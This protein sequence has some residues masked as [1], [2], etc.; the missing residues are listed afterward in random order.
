MLGSALQTESYLTMASIEKIDKLLDVNE[1]KAKKSV[2]KKDIGYPSLVDD[3]KT[4]KSKKG[5]K[6]LDV[7]NRIQ[8][9]LKEAPNSPLFLGRRKP[10]G[11]DSKKKRFFKKGK[12]PNLT[13]LRIDL[14][15]LS[16]AG[17]AEIHSR[18]KVREDLLTYPDVPDLHVISAV[19]TYQDIP[20]VEDKD[21][22]SKFALD[23]INENQLEQLKKA[24]HD[25]AVAF[26][27]GGL[28]IFNVN[29]FMKI[30]L[31]FLN[32]YKDRLTY[33]Y[34]NIS[35][36]QDAEGNSLIKKLRATQAE[37]KQMQLIKQKTGAV[38]RLSRRLN[39]TT[40][41]TEN[42]SPMEIKRASVAIKNGEPMKIIDQE[43]KASNVIYVLMTML[44]LLSKVPILKNLVLEVLALI[45]EDERSLQ[46][47]KQ[48]VLTIMKISDFELK[49]SS[50]DLA[51][52]RQAA[53]DVYSH[54]KNVINK[55]VK[56]KIIREQYEVDPYLKA[57][58]LV[59]STDGL[60]NRNNYKDMLQEAYGFL[61]VVTGET[62]QLKESTRQIVVDLANRYLYQ[63]DTIMDA[64][65]WLGEAEILSWQAR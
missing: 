29:W 61:K 25:I 51:Q 5:N 49:Q 10:K 60:Y 8:M 32:V 30:Y 36:R 41:L 64:H 47:R 56:D 65:G 58:W 2:K 22:I 33:E 44:F 62:N 16:A 39:G 34:R 35:H 12:Y 4:L 3:T 7:T 9:L 55:Y 1:K 14:N 13:R 38:T 20:R 26:H 15:K 6:R 19:Y 11:A 50:G 46:L 48:M 45:P 52:M 37:I 53:S 24:I 21:Q 57:I 42:F 43:R 18:Q 59:K 27:G 31:D 40:Y 23:K 17:K 63:L 28:S 54:C